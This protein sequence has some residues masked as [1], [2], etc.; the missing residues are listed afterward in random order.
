[1]YEQKMESLGSPKLSTNP[2]PLGQTIGFYL[3][4][5]NL[6]FLLFPF[7]DGRLLSLFEG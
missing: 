1:M 7:I 4:C 3:L 2:V 5:P 6:G